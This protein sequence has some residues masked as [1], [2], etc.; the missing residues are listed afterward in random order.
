L[1]TSIRNTVTN[2]NLQLTA[3]AIRQ[4]KWLWDTAYLSHLS[5]AAEIMPTLSYEIIHISMTDEIGDSRCVKIPDTN[6]DTDM[7]DSI[8]LHLYLDLW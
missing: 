4:H 6:S 8:D 1:P 3:D 2:C 7:T 5:Y